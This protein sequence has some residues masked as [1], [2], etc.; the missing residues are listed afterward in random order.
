MRASYLSVYED[1]R[2]G[3]CL[4]YDASYAGRNRRGVPEDIAPDSVTKIGAG[5]LPDTY[6][7][8]DFFWDR[9]GD[10]LPGRSYLHSADIVW[11][12]HLACAVAISRNIRLPFNLL[13][14]SAVIDME[15]IDLIL[16]T[17]DGL[18]QKLESL[19]D[20]NP[21][22]ENDHYLIV[23]SYDQAFPNTSLST[24]WTVCYED[25]DN[26]TIITYSREHN[27]NKIV[28][29]MAR[30]YC[31]VINYI[32]KNKSHEVFQNA[33]SGAVTRRKFLASI[34]ASAA[35][36]FILGKDSIDRQILGK[37]SIDRQEAPLSE[38]GA[39]LYYTQFVKLAQETG[40]NGGKLL[41]IIFRPN[42]WGRPALECFQNFENLSINSVDMSSVIG[43]QNIF[44]G[45]KSFKLLDKIEKINLLFSG[46][47]I[48]SS[49][50]LAGVLWY[51]KVYLEDK[52]GILSKEIESE[53]SAWNL[54]GEIYKKYTKKYNDDNITEIH[55]YTQRVLELIT[56]LSTMKQKQTDS[57][58]SVVAELFL[59]KSYGAVFADELNNINDTITGHSMKYR[60]H[61]DIRQTWDALLE[62]GDLLIFGKRSKGTKINDEN[63]MENKIRLS[64]LYYWLGATEWIGFLHSDILFSKPEDY[65]C[66]TNNNIT[67]SDRL[68]VWVDIL[69]KILKR[70]EILLTHQKNDQDAA[71]VVRLE[72]IWALSWVGLVKVSR[73]AE[74]TVKGNLL[75]GDPKQELSS[76]FENN[77]EM[78]FRRCIN[79]D[80][81][82]GY[83]LMLIGGKQGNVGKL[84]RTDLGFLLK[85]KYKTSKY[86]S[87]ENVID[88]LQ[89]TMQRYGQSTEHLTRLC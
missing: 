56:K 40:L 69:N 55:P 75:V 62:L 3:E 59:L 45:K 65:Y 63:V 73:F 33:F 85:N 29:L 34:L 57:T 47:S 16:R 54:L 35:T 28:F 26:F 68:E 60:I 81:K 14:G 7:I 58:L 21:P 5:L 19:F 25:L 83:G 15:T 18:E 42:C 6:G 46:S 31:D 38:L 70:S 51:D 17:V 20:A 66:W 74:T 24:E 61:N 11:G 36:F 79:K 67:P 53:N 89:K 87:P 82:C 27:N 4:T 86:D 49:M 13:S 22:G 48:I 72:T 32:F 52:D 12:L 44:N 23:L 1:L 77:C 8:N 64:L 43:G 41:K 84:A 37:D 10:P 9:Y 39:F 71:N 2:Q 78:A 80:L 88:R 76:T 30:R 50:D